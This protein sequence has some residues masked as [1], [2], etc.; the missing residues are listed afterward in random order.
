MLVRHLSGGEL[1]EYADGE[2]VGARRRRAQGHLSRCERCASAL[3]ASWQVVGEVR[4]CREAEAPYDLRLRIA[5]R[6]SAETLPPVSCR[7]AREFIQQDLD[8]ELSLVSAG[9]LRLHLDGCPVCAEEQRALRA[10]TRL[11]RSLPPVAAPAGIWE[12]A[13]A[14]RA[15]PALSWGAR[16][17]PVAVAAAMAAGAIFLGL[18]SLPQPAGQRAAQHEARPAA[19]RAMAAA[20]AQIAAESMVTEPAAPAP[21]EVARADSEARQPAPVTHTRAARWPSG[22][23]RQA[24]VRNVEQPPVTR[25]IAIAATRPESEP[26]VEAAAQPR[27]SRGLR[28]LAMMAKAVSSESEGRVSLG[29]QLEPW[30]VF[31]DETISEV[32]LTAVVPAAAS[33]ADSP[34][35]PASQPNTGAQDPRPGVAEAMRRAA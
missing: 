20:P 25:V 26:K 24:V 32:P 1:T 34:G 12:K 3:E 27:K 23:V 2:M 5:S 16:L 29:H 30:E 10:A 17:R 33:G 31:G 19:P 8:G 11:V 35:T 15:R 22:A 14:G 13:V 4:A 18:H 6:V 21:A 9:L 28:A 7:V